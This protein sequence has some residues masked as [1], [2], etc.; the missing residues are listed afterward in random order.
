MTVDLC[1][2]NSFHTELDK[3]I[4]SAKIYD[5]VIRHRWARSDLKDRCNR[6]A[7]E[8]TETQEAMTEVGANQEEYKRLENEIAGLQSEIMAA[9]ERFVG[10]KNK[11]NAK[12]RVVRKLIS[13]LMRC[14]KVND[15]EASDLTKQFNGYKLNDWESLLKHCDKEF[16]SQYR[17]QYKL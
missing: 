11:S 15:D 8:L 14:L 4:F 12:D 10:W 1:T 6:L 3:D 17:G 2:R 13:H 16:Y 5:I 9:R 7:E